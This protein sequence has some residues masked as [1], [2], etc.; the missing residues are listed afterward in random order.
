MFIHGQNV[1]VHLLRVDN[2][3]I[4]LSLCSD[5][6]HSLPSHWHALRA[7]THS[8]QAMLIVQHNQYASVLTENKARN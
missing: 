3:T 2:L 1:T 7:T 8:L 6:Q 5:R 4:N